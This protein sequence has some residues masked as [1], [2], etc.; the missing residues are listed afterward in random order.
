[1]RLAIIGDGK[2]GRAIATLATE[3]GHQV[4]AL[5][6]Q[7]ENEGASWITAEH[8]AQIDVAIEFTQPSAATDNI[9]ACLAHGVP[10]VTGTTG[11][12]ASLPAL[13]PKRCAWAARCSG[14]PTSR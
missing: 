5:L 8:A 12:Y 13:R 3:R 2:M 7:R 11:W 6:G 14:P 4:V 10:V 1:M 9:F